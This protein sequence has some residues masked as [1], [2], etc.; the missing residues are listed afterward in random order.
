MMNGD[1]GCGWITVDELEMV[2][3]VGNG[4]IKLKSN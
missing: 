2:G 1:V 4:W 3:G